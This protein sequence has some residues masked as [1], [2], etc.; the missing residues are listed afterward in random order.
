MSKNTLICIVGPTAVG[1]TN[2]AIRLAKSLSAEILSCDSRQ[3]FKEMSIGTAKPT[4]DEMDGVYHH[5][6]DSHSI[7]DSYSVGDFE[8]DCLNKLDTIF[9]N[10]TVAIMVGGSGLYVKAVCEGLDHFPSIDSSIRKRLNAKFEEEGITPLQQKLKELDPNCYSKIDLQNNQRVI[11]ALEVCIGT[12]QPYSSFLK[13]KQT[14]RPF[15]IL[16]IGI[17][18]ERETLFNRINLRVDQMMEMGLLKE[19]K[20][21]HPFK[22]INSLQTVGYQELFDHFEGKT[23]LEEAVELIKRNSRRYAKRQLTW[24]RK[25]NNTSWHSPDD[26]EN[27]LSK[28]KSKL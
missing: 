25:D 27:I 6:I 23:S 12:N 8:R 24:F 11:R 14:D 17:N 18:M 5:F 7:H 1:K 21:L 28:V 4:R 22:K 13:N 20:K 15:N 9:E 3:F 10:T 2:V 26:V 19:A 16:K